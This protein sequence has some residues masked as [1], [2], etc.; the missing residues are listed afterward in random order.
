MY[1]ISNTRHDTVPLCT[2]GK[3]RLRELKGLA[4]LTQLGSMEPRLEARF[5]LKARIFPLPPVKRL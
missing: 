1:V 2:E 4:Q 3:W 5:A